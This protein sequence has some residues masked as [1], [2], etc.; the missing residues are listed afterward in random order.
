MTMLITVK[1]MGE[2]LA[3][4][5]SVLSIFFISVRERRNIF[6]AKNIMT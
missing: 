3:K 5:F 4:N 1:A 6:T 2:T